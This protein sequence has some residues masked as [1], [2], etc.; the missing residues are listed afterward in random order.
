MF[1]KVNIFIA[2]IQPVNTPMPTQ[3]PTPRPTQ[4]PFPSRTNQRF[5]YVCADGLD[6]CISPNSYQPNGNLLCFQTTTDESMAWMIC[7]MYNCDGIITNGLNYEA[8]NRV[9]AYEQCRG[10]NKQV[11]YI[12]MS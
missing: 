7:E 9:G 6:S 5:G 11:H 10:F 2:I 3:R 4:R 1:I 12:P 8:V